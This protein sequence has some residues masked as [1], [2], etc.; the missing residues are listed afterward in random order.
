MTKRAAG[1][2]PAGPGVEVRIVAADNVDDLARNLAGADSLVHL[3]RRGAPQLPQR[4]E[5]GFLQRTARKR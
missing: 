4:R 1:A 3:S 2:V 5:H